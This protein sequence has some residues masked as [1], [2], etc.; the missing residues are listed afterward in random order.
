MSGDEIDRPSAPTALCQDQSN[1]RRNAPSA[2]AMSH[3]VPQTVR[4]QLVGLEFGYLPR[5]GLRDPADERVTDT[6]AIAEAIL[7]ADTPNGPYLPSL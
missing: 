6:L 7:G 4:P 2:C 5:L 1:R 3:R